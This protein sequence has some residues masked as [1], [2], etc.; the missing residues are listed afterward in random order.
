MLVR[1]NTQILVGGG[2]LLSGAAMAGAPVDAGGQQGTVVQG[3]NA[4]I[5]LNVPASK[6]EIFCRPA[7][8][9]PTDLG[10]TQEDRLAWYR[11]NAG[12]VAPGD[13]IRVIPIHGRA[14]GHS[15]SDQDLFR[16]PDIELLP[17]P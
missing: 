13:A 1:L 9:V 17:D 15:M 5:A 12:E 4:F 8:L 16:I 6:P 3:S 11:S 10:G 2:L 7:V 14:L